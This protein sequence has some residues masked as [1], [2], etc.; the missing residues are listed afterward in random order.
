MSFY[1]IIQIEYYVKEIDKIYKRREFNIF[2]DKYL[3]GSDLNSRYNLK[4]I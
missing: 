1:E 4:D 3:F 2:H